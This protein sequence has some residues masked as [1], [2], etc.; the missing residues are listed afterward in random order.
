MEV[1][2][3]RAMT[4]IIPMARSHCTMCSLAKDFDIAPTKKRQGLSLMGWMNWMNRH[5]G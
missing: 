1:G 2:T 5:F 4:K 3:I